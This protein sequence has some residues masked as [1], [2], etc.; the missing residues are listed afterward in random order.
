MRGG[1]SFASELVGGL[2]AHAGCGFSNRAERSNNVVSVMRR[3]EKTGAAEGGGGWG[4]KTPRKQLGKR[5][6]WSRV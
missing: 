5:S 1:S 2:S 4:D 3:G 6:D